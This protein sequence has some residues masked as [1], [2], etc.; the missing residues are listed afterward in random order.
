MQ[1][2]PSCPYT[3]LSEKR[4]VY[5]EVR[6]DSLDTCP[7]NLI[8]EVLTSV[9]GLYFIVYNLYSLISI[10]TTNSTSVQRFLYTINSLEFGVSVPLLSV[11][12][13]SCSSLPTF[14]DKVV[15]SSAW[16]FWS[17]TQQEPIIQ[18]RDVKCQKKLKLSYNAAKIQHSPHLNLACNHSSNSCTGLLETHRNPRDCGSRIIDDPYMKVVKLP[19]QRTGRLYPAGNNRY[20]S[21]RLVLLV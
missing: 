11:S 21:L 17:L 6:I 13:S 18:L 20:F 4:C 5:C 3:E 7:A 16:T 19:A 8:F 15:V 14:G 1:K 9:L 12:A 10:V 2:Q